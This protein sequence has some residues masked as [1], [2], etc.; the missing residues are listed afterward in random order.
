MMKNILYLLN[1]NDFY[2]VSEDV[3]IA[4]GKY[5]LPYSWKD[6]FSKIKRHSK[7]KEYTPPTWKGIWN[8]IKIK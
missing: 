6:A 3:D 4:K 1:S 2:T 7:R 8:K 5:A